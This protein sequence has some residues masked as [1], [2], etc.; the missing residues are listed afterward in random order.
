MT[1]PGAGAGDPGPRLDPAQIRSFGVILRSSVEGAGEVLRRLD[2]ACRALGVDLLLEEHA[3]AQA[4]RGSVRF[5]PMADD[6]PQVVLSLGGDGTLLRAARLMMGR[7]VPLL[8]INLGNLGFLTSAGAGEVEV[9]LDRLMAGEFTLEPRFTL[10]AEVHGAGGVE[11]EDDTVF[12][13]LNDVVIHKAG[14]A[15]V[16]RLEVGVGR[17][18]HEEELGSF[19]GDGVIVSTPT[20]STAY[21]LSA[22]GPIVVPE[23]ECTTVTPICPHTLAVRPVVVPSTQAVVVRPLEP[24][25]SLVL[26]VDGQ[27]GR[28]LDEGEW[29][30]VVRG[31]APLTLI[32]FPERTFFGTLRRKLKWAARPE[33]LDG[34]SARAIAAPVPDL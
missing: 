18:G 17:P 4:P 10:R 2:T 12:R 3:L 33:G 1:D 14:A 24:D 23:M 6:L 20:G 30:R 9:S 25:P 8:G 29:V 5:D 21:N 11:G 19:S 22:G 34:D 31:G 28:H 16:A 27:D 26:T 13:A 7:G 32:R 15:R